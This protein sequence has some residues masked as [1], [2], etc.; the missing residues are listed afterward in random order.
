MKQKVLQ[1]KCRGWWR[2]EWHHSG[3][4]AAGVDASVAVGILAAPKFFSIVKP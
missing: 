2:I 3:G 4:K 1:N